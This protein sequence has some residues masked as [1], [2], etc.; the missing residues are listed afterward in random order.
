LRRRRWVSTTLP[1]S[2]L[3][4]SLLTPATT[5]GVVRPKEALMTFAVE[6]ASVLTPLMKV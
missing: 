2:A 4:M 6:L 5:V 3:V 1:I